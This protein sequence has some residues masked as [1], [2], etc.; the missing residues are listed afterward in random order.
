MNNYTKF[1]QYKIDYF[2][3]KNNWN[4]EQQS[5]NNQSG[6]NNGKFHIIDEIYFW[7][8]QMR[9][10]AL[11]L[12]S[13]LDRD[14][15]KKFA[16]N[17]HVEWKNFMVNNFADKGIKHNDHKIYLTDEEINIVESV[18]FNEVNKHIKITKDF[19]NNIITILNKGEWI[20]WIFL[21][22]AEHMLH[23]TEYFE[24]KINNSIFTVQNEIDFI[25][26]HNS[27]EMAVT[28]QLINPSQDQ[29]HI[30]DLIRSYALVSMSSL[31][32]GKSLT[33]LD[34]RLPFPK[35]WTKEEEAI[36]KKL[37]ISDDFNMLFLA[38]KYSDELAQFVEDSGKKIEANELKTLISPILGNHV[39]RELVRF[40]D[41]LKRLQI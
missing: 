23:E 3:I 11:F 36:I 16:W 32:A 35:I 37:Q 10:H 1:L 30:I 17:L 34:R 39:H 33:D 25:N 5:W 8:H 28:A 21:A 22:L 4:D 40:T 15:L 41:T 18:D 27:S 6:G 7:T 31:E 13:G 24:K 38:I 20:G 29:Q 9:E 12:H 2:N 19:L 26:D 14:D